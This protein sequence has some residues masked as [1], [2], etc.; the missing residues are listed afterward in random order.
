[1]DERKTSGH[2]EERLYVLGGRYITHMK[3]KPS[4]DGGAFRTKSVS[5]YYDIMV[6]N[7][8]KCIVLGRTKKRHPLVLWR[9]E[10]EVL[11]EAIRNMAEK[12][13]LKVVQSSENPDYGYETMNGVEPMALVIQKRRVK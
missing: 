12:E 9:Q 10:T 11:R 2:G 5:L 3:Y 1:M 13:G 4:S 6:I 8:R 7:G